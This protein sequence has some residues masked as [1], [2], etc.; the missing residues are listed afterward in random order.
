[1]YTRH[2]VFLSAIPPCTPSPFPEDIS[3][4]FLLVIHLLKWLFYSK[5]MGKAN[6]EQLKNI[7]ETMMPL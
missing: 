2:M 6:E 3:F 1:M 7:M 4:M 5:S